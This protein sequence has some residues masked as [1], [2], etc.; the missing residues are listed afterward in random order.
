MKN[1][2]YSITLIYQGRTK[3]SN[4]TWMSYSEAFRRA[5]EALQD[6]KYAW[7]VLIHSDQNTGIIVTRKHYPELKNKY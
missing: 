2:R 4:Y 7:G 5:G 3:D 6:H 1:K